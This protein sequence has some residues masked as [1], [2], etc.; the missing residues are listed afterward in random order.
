[1]RKAPYASEKDLTDGLREYGVFVGEDVH[2]AIIQADMSH[3]HQRRAYENGSYRHQHLF[4]VTLDVA[5]FYAEQL[6][7]PANKETVIGSILHDSVEDDPSMSLDLLASTFGN[8]VKNIVE[9]LTKIELDQKP[10]QPDWDRRKLVEYH[11][12]YEQLTDAPRSSRIIKG[13]D[14]INNITCLPINDH[15]KTERIYRKTRELF[16]PWLQG[17]EPLIYPILSK[18]M[19]RLEDRFKADAQQTADKLTELYAR[20]TAEPQSNRDSKLIN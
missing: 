18:E 8:E 11:M 7:T 3:G 17:A 4:P 14:R 15:D 19:T 2:A 1:M 5:K 9:P 6:K 12:L 16:M 13:F 20:S 10:S